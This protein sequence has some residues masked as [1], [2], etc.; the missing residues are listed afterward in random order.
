MTGIFEQS[1][2]AKE[3]AKTDMQ[4]WRTNLTEEARNGRY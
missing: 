4:T 1:E 2:K 3:D